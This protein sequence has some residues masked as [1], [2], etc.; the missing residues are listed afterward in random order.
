MKKDSLSFVSINNFLDKDSL[1][2]LQDT[3]LNL[4]YRPGTNGEYSDPETGFRGRGNQK[5]ECSEDPKFHHG[6]EHYFAVDHF[7]DDP[8]LKKIKD[9]FFLHHDFKPVEI[10]AHLRHNTAHPWPHVDGDEKKSYWLFLLYV[11][12]EPLLYNGT[13]F[14]G[15]NKQLSTYVGFEENKALFF[16]AGKIFHTDLQA[17]G[18]SSPRYTLNIGYEEI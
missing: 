14:Y 15:A 11:K 10:R 12:G 7:K 6:Y 9:A 2:G 8:I 3:I 17:L 13:G 16:N 1:K 5:E 4:S 18:E